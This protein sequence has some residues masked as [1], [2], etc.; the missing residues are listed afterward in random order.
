M[1]DIGT[2]NKDKFPSNIMIRQQV[3]KE[4]EHMTTLS[5]SYFHANSTLNLQSPNSIK[6]LREPAPLISLEENK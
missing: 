4:Q 6:N 2:S 3:P 1:S 5:K